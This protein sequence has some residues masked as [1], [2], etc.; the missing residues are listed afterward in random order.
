[1]VNALAED[2]PF[3]RFVR[4]QIAADLLPEA[5]KS[6]RAALGF[7]TLGRRFLNNEPDIIDD[8]IDVISRGILGLT[9][10]CARCHDH[11][12]DPITMRDYY[13]LYAILANS[14]ESRE[15]PR[16]SDETLD[17]AAKEFAREQARR[18][19]VVKDFIRE[20]MNERRASFRTEPEVRRY[21][22]AAH[23]E[24]GEVT[25]IAAEGEFNPF[26]WQRWKDYLDTVAPTD[27]VL[28]PW[29]QLDRVPPEKFAAEAHRVAEAVVQG[30]FHPRIKEI[31]SS[32]PPS[33]AELA[34]RY[35]AVLCGSLKDQ[36]IDAALET[37]LT[38]PQSPISVPD[39]M[40]GK[41]FGRADRDRQR[42][43]Q[44]Q[45]DEWRAATPPVLAC[46]MVVKDRDPVQVQKL[47][48]RGNPNL[49]GEVTPPGMPKLLEPS[50]GRTFQEGSG[51]I[52]L[53]RALTEGKARDLMARV[54]V[55]R[56]WA[57]HFGEGLSRTPSDFGSLGDTPEQKE[58]LDWL[59]GDFQDHGFSLRH[60]HRTIVSSAAY[61]QSSESDPRRDEIDP[62]NRLL[63]RQNRRRLDFE[64]LRDRILTAAGQLDP[65]SGGP[66]SPLF[67]TPYTRVRT[68]YGFV[69]R[70]NL[71]SVWVALDGP[72]PD[73]HLAKRTTTLTPSQGLFWL[74]HPF[75]LEMAY[76]ASGRIGAQKDKI[77][78]LYRAILSRDP[79]PAERQ[80]CAEAIQSLPPPAPPVSRPTLWTFGYGTKSK[81][82]AYAFFQ[83][84]SHF[85]GESWQASPL[86]PRPGTG[87]MQ[88]T[89]E[90]GHPAPGSKVA[91]IRRFRVPAPGKITIE[92][93][94]HHPDY[95]GDGVF[96]TI[97]SERQGLLWSAKVHNGRKEHR[98]E[99]DAKEG[100]L[101]DF[102]TD[103]GR[104]PGYDFFFWSPVLRHDKLGEFSATSG[105]EGPPFPRL[106]E[107]GLLAQ[108][109]MWTT[110]FQWIR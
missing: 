8:R 34:R 6:D 94:V 101:I 54:I 18:D 109:L 22:L 108:T 52:D 80:A 47:M 92:G 71:P 44:R 57:W 43:L 19:K 104:D 61:R 107:W 14:P 48:R 103:C 31:L 20:R 64:S 40:P 85:T 28:G 35:A 102:T 51:R 11:K 93:T 105:F 90:G 98:I 86:L 12:S 9:V 87:K 74:N 45:A 32:P 60:L 27:P 91:V 33:R 106:D 53:A 89:A 58:L 15:M 26:V 62:D 76:H 37:I 13:G 16:V 4:L 65:T 39:D 29:R 79:T 59:A 1:V 41:L 83:P 21:L 68:L 56:V 42:E 3:D 100:E 110:E 81:N 84:M 55:N 23:A 77:G 38:G 69:D 67:T 99:I 75:V 72:N 66:P 78:A 97:R 95:R 49:L 88:L 10:S 50:T 96:A 70:Q 73:T 24:P 25:R 17:D 46:A 2:M 36:E 30:A 63:S 82:E 7:L 5:R